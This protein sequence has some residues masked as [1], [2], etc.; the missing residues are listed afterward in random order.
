MNHTYSNNN[1]KQKK[2]KKAFTIFS[3]MLFLILKFGTC[4][5]QVF[6][7]N[8]HNLPLHTN[9]NSVRVMIVFVEFTGPGVPNPMSANWPAGQLPLDK[10][11]YI[12]HSF[13]N[14]P[15]KYISKLMWE[16]SFGQF[17]VEGDYVNS[18]IQIDVSNMSNGP[19]LIAVKLALDNMA[20]NSTLTFGH[21][22]NISEFDHYTIAG[23]GHYYSKPALVNNRIDGL[24]ICYRNNATKPCSG[25]HGCVEYAWPPGTIGS[26]GVDVGCDFGMCGGVGGMEFIIEEFFHAMYGDNNWHAGSGGGHPGQ[27]HQI[28]SNFLR[29]SNS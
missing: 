13:T 2:M 9:G 28:S 10:D 7:Q 22:N 20:N 19:D 5:C 11:D 21:Y 8:G 14:N 17:K 15:Q 12:D 23:Q 18:L 3:F 29:Y 1:L 4:K 26:Y 6:S 16:S 24:I 25:G 27:T